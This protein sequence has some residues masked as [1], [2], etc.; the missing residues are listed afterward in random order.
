MIYVTEGVRSRTN[1][2][3]KHDGWVQLTYSVSM[4]FV[5]DFDNPGMRARQVR[6]IVAWAILLWVVMGGLVASLVS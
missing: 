3:G 5:P 6:Q 1:E 2:A 4:R